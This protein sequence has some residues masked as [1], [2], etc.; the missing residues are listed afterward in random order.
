[1]LSHI[2]GVRPAR[3]VRTESELLLGDPISVVGDPTSD[4]G[5][6]SDSISDTISPGE[7]GGAPP[8]SPSR[9]PQRISADTSRDD[10]V[11]VPGVGCF[12]QEVLIGE[13]RITLTPTP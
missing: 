9:R 7:G 11:E 4:W 12:G 10:L 2:D 6:M 1:M 8:T 3:R 13:R 5:P